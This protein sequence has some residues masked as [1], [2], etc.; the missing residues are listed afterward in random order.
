MKFFWQKKPL[1][2]NKPALPH[3]EDDG[4]YIV[5][6]LQAVPV[7]MTEE[8]AC[9]RREEQLRHQYGAEKEKVGEIV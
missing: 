5:P 1:D 8:L 9:R 2:E 3:G 6:V 4:E 7:D